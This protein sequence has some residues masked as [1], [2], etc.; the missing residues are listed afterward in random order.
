MVRI[1]ELFRVL[2]LFLFGTSLLLYFENWL[3]GIFNLDLMGSSVNWMPA[4][5]NLIII[6]MLYRNWLQF[7]GW[8]KS[9]KNIKLSQLT[10]LI[11]LA[12]TI[13]LLV[14]PFIIG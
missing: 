2:A 4:M 3:Y 8:F 7:S 9:D 1:L 13:I 12:I 11:L 5:A 14:M 10:T 6:F